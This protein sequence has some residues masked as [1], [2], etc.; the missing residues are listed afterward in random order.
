MTEMVA[1]AVTVII[2]TIVTTAKSAAVNA[3]IAAPSAPIVVS[4]RRSVGNVRSVAP[5]ART[6]LA[7][8][9][10]GPNVRNVRSGRS[11]ASPVRHRAPIVTSRQC[12][13]SAIC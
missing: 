4:G 9:L 11:V 5:S 10:T 6:V 8:V 12:R 3:R 1:M 2:G 13:R 7:S